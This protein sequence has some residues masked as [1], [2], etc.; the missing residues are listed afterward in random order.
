MN[1]EAGVKGQSC[2]V[3]VRQ[4]RRF[5][6]TV[7]VKEVSNSD[8]CVYTSAILNCAGENPSMN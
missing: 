8:P 1:V 2:R 6:Y 5:S 4:R 7:R 3:E